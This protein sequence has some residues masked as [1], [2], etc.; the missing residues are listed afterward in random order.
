MTVLEPVIE[1]LIGFTRKKVTL[2]EVIDGADR[3]RKPVLRVLDRLVKE[4]YLEETGDNKISAKLGEFGRDRRN[5]TWRILQRPLLT[6]F[7]PKLKNV[8]VRDRMW[9]LI[10]ARRYVT[11]TDLMRFTGA[12]M[13]SATDFTQ[14]LVQYGFLRVTG[15]S[16]RENLYML[17]NDPGATR[18][19]TP[20][21]KKKNVK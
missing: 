17:I 13:G 10:R 12:R 4:D 7:R 5:P 15:K 16:G 20:E 19:I 6:E 18:P 11:R 3:P 14:L 1:F 2:S 9:R 8:T 21:V